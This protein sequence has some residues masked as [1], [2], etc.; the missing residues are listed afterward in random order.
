PPGANRPVIKGERIMIYR[1][2]KLRFSV[3][4]LLLGL[5]LFSNLSVAAAQQAT[6]TTGT[7]YSSTANFLASTGGI[8]EVPAAG[9]AISNTFS[10]PVLTPQIAW[11][12]DLTSAY[13]S[14][15]GGGGGVLKL[16]PD[17]TAA[18]FATLPDAAFAVGTHPDGRVLVAL[19]N[20]N[21]VLDI[22]AGGTGPFPLYATV[23]NF[24]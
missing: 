12:P 5:A 4:A 1:N 19:L 15:N 6:F 10:I 7:V 22:S 11:S 14:T 16:T 18:T 23:P 8:G 9:G 21:Q 13:A 2:I 17:G 3:L 24:A 20:T